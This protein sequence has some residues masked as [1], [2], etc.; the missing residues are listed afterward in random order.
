LFCVTG[1]LKSV[2]NLTL[3]KKTKVKVVELKLQQ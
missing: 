1:Y 3:K 2:F